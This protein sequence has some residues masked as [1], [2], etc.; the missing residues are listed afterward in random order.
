MLEKLKIALIGPGVMGEAILSGLINSKT[1]PADAIIISGPENDRN[2][3]LQ[4]KYH[5]QVA[6]DNGSAAANADVIVLAVKPQRFTQVAK[7]LKGKIP[8]G[9]V[10][11]SIIA[12]V[13]LDNL[14]NALGNPNIIRA[15][16]RSVL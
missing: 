13:K 15:M 8:T 10:I 1:C 3:W 14:A 11:V 6:A 12:G 5:V 7:S 2:S 16:Y 4:Q 9:A